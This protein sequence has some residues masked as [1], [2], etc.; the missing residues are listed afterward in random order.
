MKRRFLFIISGFIL[1]L[2]GVA[3]QF[4]IQN[5]T[6]QGETIEKEGDGSWQAGLGEYLEKNLK[7]REVLIPVRN[8]IMYSLFRTSPNSNIVIG[9]NNNLFEEEYICFESQIYGAMSPE[10]VEALVNKLEIINK[11]LVDKGKNLFIFITPSKAEIYPEDMPSSYINI[12]PEQKGESTYQLF[13]NALNG[14]DIPFYDSTIDVR[15]MKETSEFDVF[16]RTGT[17]WSVVTAA[18]CAE[19][20]ADSMEEQLGINLPESEVDYELCKAPVEPDADIYNLLNLLGKPEEE[21]YKPVVR[22][23]DE[24]KENHTIFARGG[25]FMGASVRSLIQREYFLNS[26]YLENT[27]ATCP[28][29]TYSGI[30]DS[31]DMLS[32][33]EMIE[34][35]DIIL[36]E[37][38]EEAIPRMSFGLIDYLLDNQMIG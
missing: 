9:K 35:S 28:E 2:M 38:N 22:I 29:G 25:S 37:V 20:L 32:I 30:F 11:Q 1:L 4:V 21:Y 14:T 19:K 27:F 23:V 18:V 34:D 17:H 15:E 33:R 36:L 6:L 5:E 13:M 8:Q 24:N 12:A 7:I 31:Y 16:P 3:G 10:D 26:Y